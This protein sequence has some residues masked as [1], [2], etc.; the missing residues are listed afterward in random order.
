[1]KPIMVYLITSMKVEEVPRLSGSDYVE[2]ITHGGSPAHAS[3]VTASD[4]VLLTERYYTHVVPITQICFADGRPDLYVAYS[5]E[6]ETL[7]GVPVRAMKKRAEVEEESAA[8][9]AAKFNILLDTARE[10]VGLG[11]WDRLRFLFGR[12]RLKNKPP[13][14]VVLNIC[15]R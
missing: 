11:F 2:Y 10:L 7:I 4:H 1:V 13:K 3:R 5:E 12:Y 6:V 8:V 14:G 15:L 9:N